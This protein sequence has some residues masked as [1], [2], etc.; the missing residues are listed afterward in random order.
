MIKN[1]KIGL[2]SAAVVI[3]L[4]IVII[5]V[6]MDDIENSMYLHSKNITNDVSEKTDVYL[7]EKDNEYLVYLYS[8]KNCKD[9][10]SYIKDLKKYEESKDA[11]PIYKINLDKLK[12]N[13]VEN[14]LF[15]HTENPVIFVVKGGE[16]VFQY[17]GKYDTSKL[18][19]KVK[20][21]DNF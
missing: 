5:F 2:I 8:E 7:K 14:E 9:C 16:K 13:K 20:D 19:N 15:V 11:Y 4:A 17:T 6:K 3:I 18:A 1:K 12:Q 21:I 10:V